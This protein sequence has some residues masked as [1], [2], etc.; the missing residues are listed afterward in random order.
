MSASTKIVPNYDYPNE[1]PIK[2]VDEDTIV[3]VV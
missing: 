1:H 3:M 2:H